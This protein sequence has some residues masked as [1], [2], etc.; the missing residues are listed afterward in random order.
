MEVQEFW[1]STALS[2]DLRLAR[3]QPS[4]GRASPRARAP[5]LLAA[6]VALAHRADR[7]DAL[8]LETDAPTRLRS[9]RARNRISVREVIAGA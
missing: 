7:L 2:Q 5:A 8:V 4:G 6:L 1:E 9:P 3:S